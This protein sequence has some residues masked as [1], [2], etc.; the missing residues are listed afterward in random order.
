MIVKLSGMIKP[1][2]QAEIATYLKDFV[3]DNMCY[4]MYP[5]GDLM[6]FQVEFFAEDPEEALTLEY[7]FEWGEFGVEKPQYYFDNYGGIW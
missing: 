2:L 6:L 1:H 5:N 3:V 4:E 7:L